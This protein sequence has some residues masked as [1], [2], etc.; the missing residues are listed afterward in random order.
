[1]LPPDVFVHR[2][3]TSP[4]IPLNPSACLSLLARVEICRVARVGQ[5]DGAN[6]CPPAIRSTTSATVHRAT[7]VKTVRMHRPSPTGPHGAHGASASG[8]NLPKPASNV[9]TRSAPASASSTHLVRSAKGLVDAS[10][11]VFAISTLSVLMLPN[12]C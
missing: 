5:V 3:R 2:R 10:D 9:R 11:T 8:Q 12:D 1:M 7:A 4:K 6:N